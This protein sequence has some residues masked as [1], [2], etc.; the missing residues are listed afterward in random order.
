MRATR[1]LLFC[2]FL[3]LSVLGC[4]PDPRNDAHLFLDR[5]ERIDLD[6]P[7]EV[8]RR[9]VDSLA[10]LPVTAE[11]VRLARDAC[12][13]AH[14]AVIE[15][16]EAAASAREILEEYEDEASIPA[17][18]RQ[19]FERS[20]ETSRRAMD[21][22]RNLFRSCHDRTNDLSLRYRNRRSG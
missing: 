10:T 9:R 18:E 12:V 3:L 11:V 2:L 17:T 7:V 15:A 1:L 14:R 4:E 13:D 16:E 22:S 6:D 21:R 8:R 5:V 20:I 19:R